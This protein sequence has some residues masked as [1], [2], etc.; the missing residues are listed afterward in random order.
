MEQIFSENWNLSSLYP[1]EIES[2]KLKELIS[3]LTTDIDK[4]HKKIISFDFPLEKK[5]IPEIIQLFH[6]IQDVMNGSL[7]LD[8]YLICVYSEDVKNKNV[9]NLMTESSKIKADLN[10]LLVELDQLLVKIPNEAWLRLL[11]HEEVR[12]Y[13][14]YLEERK[15]MM[16]NKLPAEMEILMNDLSVSGFAGWENHY[17]LLMSKL[18]IPDGNGRVLS[19]GQALN[20]AMS[21]SNRT[22]REK[23]AHSIIEVSEKQADFFASILNHMTG[24]R[25]SMYKKRGWDNILKESLD[26]NRINEQTL[27]TMIS[28]I[29]E[30]KNVIKSFI[31]RKAQVSKINSLGW[32]DIM[33]PSFTTDQN[34]TYTDAAEMVISQFHRFSK[35]LGLFAERAFQEGWIEAENRANKGH[36]AFC[37]S[38]PLAKESRIFLTFAGS[39]QDVVTIAHELG[40]AY[41]NY[42]LH[43][44][45]AFSQQKGTSVAETASTFTENLVL[46]AAIAN[47]KNDKEK[48]SLLEMKITNGLK[49]IGV[50]PS[51]FEFEQK[52]YEKRKHGLLTSEEITNLM[53]EIQ[54][55]LYSETIAELNP[56]NWMTIS[57]FYNTEQAFYTIPY[58]IG[59]LFSNGI[60]ALAKEQGSPF[61]NQYDELLRNSGKLTV[62]QL[63]ERYLNQDITKKGFWE[64]SIQSTLDAVNEY[65]LITEKMI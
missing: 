42:I 28:T 65:L 53:E 30:H 18:E 16:K 64:A 43:E 39:Y 11:Q 14:F 63:A 48:L 3:R 22:I 50:V 32:Y 24:Y 34:V 49:Y 9:S 54:I 17:E 27:Q 1:G 20:Q 62:E 31:K 55:D 10:S 13:Q 21:A 2:L 37:A 19:I 35:K 5:N 26:Q 45:P 29:N 51:M 40:H 15:R 61:I 6:L 41:H 60:Y 7:E 44:E 57:H 46:D 36:G 25:L 59:F 4:L 33:A 23:T 8:D 58:T 56:Y 47:A 38:M 12:T 52:L